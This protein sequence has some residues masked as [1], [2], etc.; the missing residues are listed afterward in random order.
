[1]DYSVIDPFV[2]VTDHHTRSITKYTHLDQAPKNITY[3]KQLST[4]VVLP[5]SKMAV[6]KGGTLTFGSKRPLITAADSVPSA[7]HAATLISQ[8]RELTPATISEQLMAQSVDDLKLPPCLNLPEPGLCQLECIKAIQQKAHKSAHTAWGTRSQRSVSALVT[9]FSFVSHV[10]VPDH[11]LSTHA[12]FSDHMIKRF[13]KLYEYY[14]GTMNK[15]H[16]LSFSTDVS[17]NKV[18][19]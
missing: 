19:T 11:E 13:E 14:D 12:M 17:S 7:S 18:F 5:Q 8:G 10:T 2:I 16:F 1:M 4:T 15:I 3:H 9:L 6:S